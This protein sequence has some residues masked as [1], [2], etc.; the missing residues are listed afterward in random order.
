MLHSFLY[1]FTAFYCY[2]P[3]ML[4]LQKIWT[5]YTMLEN[6]VLQCC[7]LTIMK[8]FSIMCLLMNPDR[9][10]WGPIVNQA[11]QRKSSCSYTITSVLYNILF[12]LVYQLVASYFLKRLQNF[13]DDPTHTL[14]A[15]TSSPSIWTTFTLRKD[16][17]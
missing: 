3:D 1:I 7:L 17:W 5:D 12:F 14:V 2:A 8:L 10:T 4:V 13:I 9:N 11:F 6:N 16:V 15:P